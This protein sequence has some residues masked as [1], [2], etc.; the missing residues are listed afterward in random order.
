MAA[1]ASVK[2]ATLDSMIAFATRLAYLS[3]FSCSTGSPL[4]ITGPPDAGGPGCQI[5]GDVEPVDTP[6]GP[7]SAAVPLAQHGSFDALVASHVIGH[8]PDLIAFLD[9]AAA[10]VTDAAHR[11][12]RR[13]Q[14]TTLSRL[15]TMTTGI[16]QGGRGG[17]RV[18]VPAGVS[19]T[20]QARIGWG[21]P[22]A[23]YWIRCPG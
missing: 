20:M 11:M 16:G 12:S 22:A 17:L 18:T 19:P 1:S 9:S 7:L 6:S 23:D 13:K 3:C 2:S 4:L 15:T 21:E 5:Y 8:T 10:L 14:T